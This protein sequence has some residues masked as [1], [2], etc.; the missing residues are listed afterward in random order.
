MYSPSKTS[1]SRMLVRAAAWLLSLT[2]AVHIHAAN[3][4]T[5]IAP[6]DFGSHNAVAIGLD[7]IPVIAHRQ[8]DANNSNIALFVTKCGNT[9][10]TANNTTSLVDGSATYSYGFGESLLAIAVASDGQPVISYVTDDSAKM[11]KCGNAAC[12]AGNVVTTTLGPFNDPNV[13]LRSTAITLSPKTGFPVIAHTLHVVSFTYNFVINCQTPS[14][15]SSVQ[16]SVAELNGTIISK[17]SMAMGSDGLPIFSY[18][19]SVN[20]G[21]GHSSF[22]VIALKCGNVSCNSGNTESVV[23]IPSPQ[24]PIPQTPRLVSPRSEHRPSIAIGP[25]G[26]PVISFV[27]YM[28]LPSGSDFDDQ[29][30][31]ALTVARCKT[32][33]CS[34]IAS[35]SLIDNSAAQVGEAN[36]IAVPA[37]GRPVISYYDSTGKRLKLAKCGN[38]SCSSQNKVSVVAT[39]VT[40]HHDFEHGG[41]WS[42]IAVPADGRPIVSFTDQDGLTP[43]VALKVLRCGDAVCT[44]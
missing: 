11:A 25:D 37:D 9:D 8:L 5:Q 23:A 42:S 43:G 38:A 32:P 29:T 6:A 41:F 22:V 36:S 14:C 35:V 19:E 40:R 20:D 30:P 44:P 12:S 15:S 16:T 27:S 26:R 28:L 21:H 13:A 33:S 3:T 39:S 4:I 1:T 34:V 24:L 2:A 10:C 7:G 18:V 31:T 17:S